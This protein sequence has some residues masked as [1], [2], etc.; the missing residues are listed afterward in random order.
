MDPDVCLKL[1]RALAQRILDDCMLGK[2]I[3]DDRAERLAEHF[4]DLDEWIMNGGSLPAEWES[5]NDTTYGGT[6]GTANS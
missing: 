5:K 1:C 2:P 3:T 6:N 4:Q